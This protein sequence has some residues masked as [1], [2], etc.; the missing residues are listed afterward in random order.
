MEMPPRVIELDDLTLRRFDPEG[1][2]AE[3][4]EVIDAARAHLRPWMT[5][6]DEHDP[7]RTAEF[8]ARREEAWEAGRDFTFAVVLGGAIVG[9]CQ[10]FRREGG[11][12]GVMEIGY[13]LHPAATGRGVATRAAGALVAE[14]F[15]FPGVEQVEIS[16]DPANRASGAVAARLGFTEDRRRSAG[17]GEELVWRLGRRERAVQEG[18]VRAAVVG[19]GAVG[20]GAVQSG[21]VEEGMVEEG[22]IEEVV[23]EDRKSFGSHPPK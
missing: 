12:G 3:L 1:D 23:T 21:M 6:V 14:A 10:L 8:L 2:R 19:S 16:H 4:F 22:V 7:D 17:T 15:R 5:W 11:P 9:A 18:A 13:W 20:A